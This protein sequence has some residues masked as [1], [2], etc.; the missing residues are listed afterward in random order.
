MFH[1]FTHAFFKALLFLASGSVM[2]AMGGVIDMR[3]FRGLRHRL[4]YTCGPSPS[5]AWR[6]RGSSRWR[7]LQQG[8]DPRGA[9]A[10]VGH[11]GRARPRH[12][13]ELL[14]AYSLIYWVARRDRLPDGV[15]HGAGL[16]PDLL[17]PEKLPSP[18][19]PEAEPAGATAAHHGPAL[20]V[21]TPAPETSQMAQY[22]AALGVHRAEPVAALHA[23]PASGGRRSPSPGRPARADAGRDRRTRPPASRLGSWA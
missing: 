1:L 15:L 6:C 10:C 18:D 22:E 20:G 9:A 23:A 12:P 21:D 5:A 17:G 4:P 13:G 7:V 11:R 3:R 14:G 2:H 8:R 19:D 16:L